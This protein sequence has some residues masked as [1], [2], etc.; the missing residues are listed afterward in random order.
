MT[1]VKICG[2]TNKED[3][4][5]AINYG[6]DAIGVINVKGTP[7]F[8]DLNKA[9]EIFDALPIFVSKVVVSM[10]ESIEEAL[11]ISKTRA[12]YIQL[13]GD[14]PLDFV[15]ELKER[16]NLGIIKKISV[17]ENSLENSE[18][19]SKIVDA[20]LLD[21]RVRG[22]SGG[23][24]KTHDW[25]ISRKIVESIRKPV[26]LA[27]GLNPRNLEEAI[28]KVRPY[29]V[30]TSSGVESR[31]GKKDKRKVEQFIMVAKNETTR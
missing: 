23:T 18:R 1:R 28:E 16:T 26:I 3:A 29:A 2:I 15:R 13:H 7:R 4:L 20:I 17:D 22:L 19:Y 30:D 6:A 12:N 24:G 11:E 25:D 27:G 9:R 10:P 31:P 14:E 8:V 5:I 21:T